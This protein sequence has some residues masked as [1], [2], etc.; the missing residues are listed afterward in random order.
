[1]HSTLAP[2]GPVWNGPLPFIPVHTGSTVAFPDTLFRG[3]LEVGVAVSAI[4]LDSVEKAAVAASFAEV[5]IP[6]LGNTAFYL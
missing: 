2:L 4:G 6:A 3:L 5:T 1:M